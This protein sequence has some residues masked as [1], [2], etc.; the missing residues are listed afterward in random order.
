MNDKPDF[1][2]TEFK[3]RYFMSDY[4]M[5]MFK[6]NRHIE[7]GISPDTE[8]TRHEMWDS[9]APYTVWAPSIEVA[10]LYIKGKGWI[11]YPFKHED[12]SFSVWAW[13]EGL[14]IKITWGMPPLH[15]GDKPLY[16]FTFVDFSPLTFKKEYTS[17]DY[18]STIHDSSLRQMMVP[19]FRKVELVNRSSP[20]T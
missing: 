8:H 16:D 1:E 15:D 7:Y 6:G 18:K 13:V 17:D 5:K 19:T 4:D 9:I 2:V 14:T 10:C 11:A 3:I 20:M 12:G